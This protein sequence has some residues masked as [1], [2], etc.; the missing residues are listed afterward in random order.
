MV[1]LEPDISS[2]EFLLKWLMKW[3]HYS[4]LNIFLRKKV[5]KYEHTA[6]FL[7]RLRK[8]LSMLTGNIFFLNVL[9]ATSLR[10][11]SPNLLNHFTKISSEMDIYFIH[12]ILLMCLLWGKHYYRC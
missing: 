4:E 7:A 6:F 2:Y 3:K 12:Q 9:N 10:L 11:S 1:L 5:E 8:K